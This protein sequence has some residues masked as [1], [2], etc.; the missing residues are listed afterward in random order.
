MDVDAGPVDT[1]EQAKLRKEKWCLEQVKTRL[2]N[3]NAYTQHLS[4]KRVM[5]TSGVLPDRSHL[6]S[7]SPSMD[8]QPFISLPEMYVDL[9][10]YVTR[11]EHV[12][13][14]EKESKNEWA[15]CLLTGAVVKAGKS[16]NKKDCGACT[17]LARSNGSGIGVF[18]LTSKAQVL[19]ISDDKSA[20]WKS[21]YL[22]SYGEEDPGLRRGRPL[23]LNAPRLREL[24]ELYL[25]SE[26]VKEVASIRGNSDRVVR[27]NWY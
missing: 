22:D 5:K 19:L 10:N 18:F 8:A 4:V 2:E 25:K 23:F 24:T 13:E 6:L 7:V 17:S 15:I 16:D 26:I 27:S 3:N 20:Y 21:I 9:Y 12:Q 11:L 14:G 1:G